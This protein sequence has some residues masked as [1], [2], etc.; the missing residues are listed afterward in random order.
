MGRVKLKFP[1]ENP[2]YV[3]TIPVRIGDINYGGHVGNDAVL[4]IMHEARMQLLGHHGATELNIDGCAL[5]MADVE[6]AYKGESFYG[7]VLTVKMYADEITEHSFS[8]LYH[9][10]VVRDGVPKDVAHGRTGLICFDYKERLIVAMGDG[11]RCILKPPAL[12]GDVR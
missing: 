3:A 12:K 4:S 10:S 8:L 9:I 1:A 6:I 2:L 7:D 11:L 5:I